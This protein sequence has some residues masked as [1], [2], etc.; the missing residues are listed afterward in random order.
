VI[1]E[2]VAAAL[3]LA[4]SLAQAGGMSRE[5]KMALMADAML[6]MHYDSAELLEEFCAGVDPAFRERF[7][8]LRQGR[9][10]QEIARAAVLNKV[11]LDKTSRR[12]RI[13][14]PSMRAL[15]EM[16]VPGSQAPAGTPPMP[17]LRMATI[18]ASLRMR[19]AEIVAPL[20][21]EGRRAYCEDALA[22][23]GPP[24]IAPARA[25]TGGDR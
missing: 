24:L 18:T 4:A 3:M 20:D 23:T 21:G 25:E 7:A 13:S 16:A 9:W 19:L 5:Q 15:A 8:E 6:Q 12:D 22:R 11:M 10:L 2:T 14:S 1:R 17:S